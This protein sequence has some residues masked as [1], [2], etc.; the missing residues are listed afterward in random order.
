M[1][2]E[3]VM[4]EENITERGIYVSLP[5]KLDHRLDV[6]TKLLPSN[7][8]DGSRLYKKDLIKVACQKFV[9]KCDEYFEGVT[10]MTTMIERAK[11][12]NIAEIDISEDMLEKNAGLSEFS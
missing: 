5:R 12:I 6:L 3:K 11:E 10:D 8:E 1:T 9:D 4:T 2:E 7:K